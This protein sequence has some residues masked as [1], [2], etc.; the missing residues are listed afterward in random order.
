MILMEKVRQKYGPPVVTH[1]TRVKLWLAPDESYWE[2]VGRGVKVDAAAVREAGRLMTKRANRVAAMMD[3][4][5]SKGFIFEADK[6]A[7]YCYS[8]TVEAYEIKRDLIAAGF[9]DP[10]FQI[11]LEYTRGWGML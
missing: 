9:K 5:A 8:T 7:I 4:M 6:M 2:N 11:L 10:E 3:V 1:L